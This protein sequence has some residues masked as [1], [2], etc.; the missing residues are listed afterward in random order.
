[1]TQQ[2]ADFTQRFESL[3]E[4]IE[5]SNE[6]VLSGQM[7]D[8]GDLERNVA[9]LCKDIEKAPPETARETNALMARMISRLDELAQS[10]THLQTQQEQG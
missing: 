2:P 8:L 7:I 10:L 9:Q 4:F 1:M 3:I 5:Q 6:K